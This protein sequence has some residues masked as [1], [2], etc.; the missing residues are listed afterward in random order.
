MIFAFVHCNMDRRVIFALVKRIRKKNVSFLELAG[1]ELHR[2][3]AYWRDVCGVNCLGVAGRGRLC[4]VSYFS[5]TRKS[6]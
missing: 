1:G 6:C 5:L 2:N 4:V 3:R